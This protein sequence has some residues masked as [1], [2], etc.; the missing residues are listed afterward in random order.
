MQVQVV[1]GR[2]H[3]APWGCW[4]DRRPLFAQ[5]PLGEFNVVP[6]RRIHRLLKY[7]ANMCAQRCACPH[8]SLASGHIRRSYAHTSRKAHMLTEYSTFCA[9]SQIRVQQVGHGI[10]QWVFV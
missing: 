6:G 10:Q 2:L 3:V 5:T 8:G 7:A 9:Y 4:T 1:V